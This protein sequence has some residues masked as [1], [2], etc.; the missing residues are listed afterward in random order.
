MAARRSY[1]YARARTASAA[2]CH[3]G[4]AGARE[5]PGQLDQVIALFPVVPES[6]ARFRHVARDRPMRGARPQ[7]PGDRRTSSDDAVA[8]LPRPGT[9]A[10]GDHS[11]HFSVVLGERRGHVV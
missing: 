2:A 9:I 1:Q 3:W 4:T 8:E 10:G 11:A 5:L 6:D 7:L